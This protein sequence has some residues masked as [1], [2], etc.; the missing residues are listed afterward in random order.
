MTPSGN[1][2]VTLGS[3]ELAGVNSDLN[4]ATKAE[5]DEINDTFM[6]DLTDETM[7]KLNLPFIPLPI[8]PSGLTVHDYAPKPMF[9]PIELFLD[10]QSNPSI[11]SAW[12]IGL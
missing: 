3:A 2:P 9:K 1:Q 7:Q 4:I 6:K 11:I 10:V 8:Q 5:I 12:F